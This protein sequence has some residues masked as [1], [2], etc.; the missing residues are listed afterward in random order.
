MKTFF[1]KVDPK[2]LKNLK[3]AKKHNKKNKTKVIITVRRNKPAKAVGA[4]KG[5]GTPK[6]TATKS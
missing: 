3:F 4:P 6:A 1:L 5:A 2:F